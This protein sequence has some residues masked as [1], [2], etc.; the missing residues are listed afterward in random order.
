MCSDNWRAGKD[1]YVTS[2]GMVG[3][4]IYWWNFIQVLK[5]ITMKT[6]I[7]QNHYNLIIFVQNT[8]LITIMEQYV[9]AQRLER[10]TLHKNYVWMVI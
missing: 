3:Q 6:K 9:F 10:S 2:R 1:Q 4:I 7:K 8:I 5:M